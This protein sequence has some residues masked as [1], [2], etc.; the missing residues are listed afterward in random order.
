MSKFDW[1]E[2]ALCREIGPELFNP[3]IGDVSMVRKAKSIC[4]RCAVI[5]PCLKY[6]ISSPG[7]GGVMG[8]KTEKE[9]RNLRLQEGKI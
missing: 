5:S 3:E 6:G 2:Q 7:I 8:G 4:A 1:M 9:R